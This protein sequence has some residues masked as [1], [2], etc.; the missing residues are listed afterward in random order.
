MMNTMQDRARLYLEELLGRVAGQQWEEGG[1]IIMTQ[2]ENEFGNY[3]YGDHPRD[4]QHLRFLKSVLRDNGVTSL[5]F[6]SDT[7]T[8]TADWGNIDHELMTANFK[9]NSEAELAR[10]KEI[11]PDSPILV[12][13]FWP[14][15]FDHWFEP[16]HNILSEQDFR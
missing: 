11:R 4:K 14:G 7:P 3:G 13:E 1:P 5:L 2:I 15:W 6:T 10:I 8:L 12:S 9:W 16:N